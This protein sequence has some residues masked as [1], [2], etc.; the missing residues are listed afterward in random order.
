AADAGGHVVLPEL[1]RRHAGVA[2][3]MRAFWSTRARI[4]KVAAVG[5]AQAFGGRTATTSTS[6]ISPSRA[7]A[8]TC[9][10]VDAGG[11][12]S[13]LRYESRTSRRIGSC[14]LA[15]VR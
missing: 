7:S 14:A 3:R 5:L 8:T 13:L 11:G 9:T 15:S 12:V 4:G 10:T 2:R 6:I 1:R